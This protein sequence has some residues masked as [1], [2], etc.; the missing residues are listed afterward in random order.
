MLQAKRERP[1]KLPVNGKIPNATHTKLETGIDV[2]FLAC[3]F[4]S[5]SHFKADLNLFTAYIIPLA[6][7]AKKY[8][9]AIQPAEIGSARN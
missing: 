1:N 4:E 6:F 9:K 8:E 5:F 7:S 3:T 2:P